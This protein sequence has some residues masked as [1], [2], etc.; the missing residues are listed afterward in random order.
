MR[1]CFIEVSTEKEKKEFEKKESVEK[2][3]VKA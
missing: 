3:I 2:D 1:R